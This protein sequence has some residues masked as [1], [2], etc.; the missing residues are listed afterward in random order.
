MT[1]T[2]VGGVVTAIN[3]GKRDGGHLKQFTTGGEFESDVFAKTLRKQGVMQ[4]NSSSYQPQS[5]GLAK[6]MVELMK[7]SFSAQQ[8]Q[9]YVLGYAWDLPVFGELVAVWK[10]LPKDRH[11]LDHQ[12]KII[13][14]LKPT[15]LDKNVNRLHYQWNKIFGN[16]RTR[17]KVILSPYRSLVLPDGQNAWMRADDG[18]ISV[19]ASFKCVP[20]GIWEEKVNE[21]ASE[22]EDTAPHR[23]G[24]G[25]QRGVRTRR[26]CPNINTFV[27]ISNFYHVDMLKKIVQEMEEAT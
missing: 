7:S 1:T 3:S 17:A 4:T 12:G 22:M 9:A 6:R 10:M 5:N 2:T 14:G 16:D 21:F 25:D 26:Q 20:S 13:K 8:Q 11:S 24:F 15:S 18:F 19:D 27:D 23:S